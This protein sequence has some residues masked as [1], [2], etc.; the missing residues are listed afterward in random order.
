M[1][2]NG[3]T[4][5]TCAIKLLPSVGNPQLA[6]SISASALKGKRYVDSLQKGNSAMG[7]TLASSL[8]DCVTKCTMAGNQCASVNFGKLGGKSV[9]EFVTVKVTQDPK[10][11]KLL[12]SQSG[13]QYACCINNLFNEKGV[14]NGDESDSD[15]SY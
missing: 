6:K 8:Q 10:L 5:L 14:A 3:W 1:C 11:Q 13:W 4:G 7:R 2:K 9:C 12:K 15:T